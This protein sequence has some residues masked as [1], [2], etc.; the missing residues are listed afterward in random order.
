MVSRDTQPI[1]CTLSAGDYLE[2]LAM[3]AA[4]TREALLSYRRRDLVVELRYDP[5]AAER[6][7][8]LVRREQECCPFL[9][10]EVT[11]GVGD[12]VR[13]SIRA[14]DEA[15]GAVELLFNQFVCPVAEDTP[16]TGT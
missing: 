15:R 2:R 1:A 12:A 11:E 13:V 16:E 3:I 8:D 7:R 10:F 9:A 4:L 5:G 6:V 14:P